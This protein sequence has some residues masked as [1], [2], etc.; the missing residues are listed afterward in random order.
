MIIG[1]SLLSFL[2]KI[3]N[4]LGNLAKYYIA[5]VIRVEDITPYLIIYVSE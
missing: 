4:A 5:D 2:R 1:I 3:I